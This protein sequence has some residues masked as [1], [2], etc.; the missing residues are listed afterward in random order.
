MWHHYLVFCFLAF[1]CALYG[2][3]ARLLVIPGLL[4]LEPCTWAE[5]KERLFNVLAH[6]VWYECLPGTWLKAVLCHIVR[7][8]KPVRTYIILRSTK[9]D[10]IPQY[11]THIRRACKSTS[12][13]SNEKQFKTTRYNAL[14]VAAASWTV[15]GAGTIPVGK[16]VQNRLFSTVHRM[17]KPYKTAVSYGPQAGSYGFRSRYILFT[18]YEVKRATHQE[19]D[20]INNK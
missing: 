11:R 7:V 18:F 15:Y 10:R 17:N 19:T 12:R 8:K 1:G 2:S 14:L 6:A 9:K 16:T 3:S 13:F 5:K 4:G 20:S